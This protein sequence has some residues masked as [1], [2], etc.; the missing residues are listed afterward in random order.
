MKHTKLNEHLMKI[1]YV[2]GMQTKAEHA[3]EREFT[4]LNSMHADV[5][6]AHASVLEKARFS[7]AY[8]EPLLVFLSVVKTD[9]V[10]VTPDLSVNMVS[11]SA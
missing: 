5:A 6:S 2:L 11:L 3:A 1:Q 4:L 8:S 9:F 10:Q 7:N